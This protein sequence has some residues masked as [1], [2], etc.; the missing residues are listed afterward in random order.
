[1]V[2]FETKT[3]SQT[4]KIGHHFGELF[5]GKVHEE[6]GSIYTSINKF[7]SRPGALT[8]GLIGE[9]G[10]GKTTFVKGLAK[11]LRIKGKITSPTYVFVRSYNLLPLKIGDQIKN[12]FYHLDLY[13]LEGPDPKV[14]DSIE[15]QEI[16]NDP[17]AIIAIEWPERLRSFPRPGE[18][19]IRLTFSYE[20]GGRRVIIEDF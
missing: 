4:E 14:L 13:R 12:R 8:I 10:S 16:V 7:G 19:W 15:F 18:N 11:G 1:M 3:A 2:N 17:E 9:L 20:A 6:L 5:R